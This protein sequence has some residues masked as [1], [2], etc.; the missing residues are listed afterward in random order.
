MI[1]IEGVEWFGFLD[2]LQYTV[3]IWTKLRTSWYEYTRYNHFCQNESK[4]I[5]KEME[6]WR[7]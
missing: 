3:D 5:V 1:A 6:K 7:L 2:L 4:S